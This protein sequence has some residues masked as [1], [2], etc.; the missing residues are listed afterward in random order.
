MSWSASRWPTG[1]KSFRLV[2]IALLGAALPTLSS[3]SQHLLLHLGPYQPSHSIIPST[4]NQRCQQR[5]STQVPILTQPL[6]QNSQSTI[7]T[8]NVQPSAHPASPTS[9][10]STEHLSVSW[11]HTQ[12]WIKIVIRLTIPQ[13]RRRIKCILCR[14]IP[15]LLDI[16]C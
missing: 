9:S 15:S 5:L 14:N 4:K 11:T 10:K 3:P 8:D 2:W 16:Y 13:L 12:Q 7:S 1:K 6:E